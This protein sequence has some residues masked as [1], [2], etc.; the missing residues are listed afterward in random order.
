MK[1]GEQEVRNAIEDFVQKIQSGE[2]GHGYT[3]HFTLSQEALDY[4]QAHGIPQPAQ[5][6]TNVLP[7][8]RRK[9]I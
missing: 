2:V 5:H 1:P 3:Y 9:I 6:G 8:K 7:F 4:L